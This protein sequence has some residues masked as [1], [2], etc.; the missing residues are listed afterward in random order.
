MLPATGEV[1]GSEGFWRSERGIATLGGPLTRKRSR[2]K[3]RR[4]TRGRSGDAAP[5]AEGAGHRGIPEARPSP[6][7]A[8]PFIPVRRRR[9]EGRS[10]CL[11]FDPYPSRR[12]ASRRTGRPRSGGPQTRLHF[13]GVVQA[14]H[15]RPR[16]EPGVEKW[17]IPTARTEKR[18]RGR[19]SPAG[20]ILMQGPKLGSIPALQT[21]D[22][23][24]FFPCPVAIAVGWFPRSSTAGPA[25]GGGARR[26][27]GR[28][29]RPPARPGA[30]QSCGCYSC[31]RSRSEV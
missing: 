12:S 20:K 5:E 3:L 25:L 21:M 14:F 10:T 19:N 7:G 11:V 6:A 31:G 1:A 8:T 17:R 24:R 30:A 9:S 28:T 15:L 2:A 13:S 26:G 16:F 4:S 27:L 29:R 18:P 22:R 23:S